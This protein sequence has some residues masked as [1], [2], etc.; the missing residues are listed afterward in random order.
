MTPNDRTEVRDM[1]HDTLEVWEK[2]TV[3]R[4]NMTLVALEKIEGHLAKINGAV[5]SHEKLIT[6]NLP[7]TVAHCS[8]TETI[9]EIRDKVVKITGVEEASSTNWLRVFQIMG[10]LIA[11]GMLILGYLNLTKKIDNNETNVKTTI[12]SE[13]RAQEG[14][15][16]VTRGGYVKYNHYGIQDS[17]KIK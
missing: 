14:I 5:A 16:G 10:T 8:Q 9:K 3:A 4:E 15:S 12:K 17:I 11:L 6:A 7:H 13:I 1:I 2:A